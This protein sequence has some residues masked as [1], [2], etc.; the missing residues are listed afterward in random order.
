M[1]RFKATGVSMLAYERFI[2]L[3]GVSK[4]HC[5]CHVLCCVCVLGCGEYADRFT[6]WGCL[7][8]GGTAHYFLAFVA[9]LLFSELPSLALLGLA[10]YVCLKLSSC[11]CE[12]LGYQSRV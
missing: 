1:L 8:C 2:L 6:C 11:L 5:T 7:K 10:C 3:R 12:F 9:L 4:Q